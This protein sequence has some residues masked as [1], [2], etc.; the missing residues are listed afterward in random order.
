MFV[1]EQMCLLVSGVSDC[2]VTCCAAC[3]LVLCGHVLV[4]FWKILN[5]VNPF[6]PSIYIVLVFLSGL[7]NCLYLVVF[8]INGC[9]DFFCFFSSFPLI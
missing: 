4:S 7:F 6:L 9:F 2:D 8:M 3:M 5:L 1:K